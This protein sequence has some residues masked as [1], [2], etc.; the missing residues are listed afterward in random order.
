MLTM[1]AQVSMNQGLRP[2]RKI[3]RILDRQCAR[4]IELLPFVR[5]CA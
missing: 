3:L 5:G 4:I 1:R 2:G